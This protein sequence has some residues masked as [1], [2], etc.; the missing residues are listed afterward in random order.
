M[1][2]LPKVVTT[3][4][5]KW[6]GTKKTSP[7][8]APIEHMFHGNDDGVKF[9]N[10][11]SHFFDSFDESN[12]STTNVLFSN[13]IQYIMVCTISSLQSQDDLVKFTNR[14][15][16]YFY[17]YR[18]I[19][20]YLNYIDNEHK[21][22]KRRK[23]LLELRII[24]CRQLAYVFQNTMGEKPKVLIMDRSVLERINIRE[25]LMMITAILTDEDLIIFLVLSNLS[26]QSSL[27]CDDHRDHSWV[28][29][30]SN[31]QSIDLSLESVVSKFIDYKQTFATVPFDIPAFIALVEKTPAWTDP[32]YSTFS[33]Y[34][35]LL[36][37]LN[38]DVKTFFDEYLPHLPGWITKNKKNRSEHIGGL[39]QHVSQWEQLFANYLSSC[40]SNM[41]PDTFWK[42]FLYL[43]EKIDFN[44]TILAQ[45]SSILTKQ[46]N[47]STIEKVI[48]RINSA[49]VTQTRLKDESSSNLMKILETVF[50]AFISELFVTEH[51]PDIIRDYT[52]LNLYDIGL[53]LSPTRNLLQQSCLTI[54]NRLLFSFGHVG[55]ISEKIRLS[56][57][58]ICYFNDHLCRNNDPRVIIKDEWLKA[59]TLPI[60][61]MCSNFTRANYQD[62][63]NAHRNHPWNIYVWSRI[64]HLNIL[65][66]IIKDPA[67]IL[68]SIGDWMKR[69]G[70][71]IYKRD[72]A[73][74]IVFVN[75]VFEN[76][77]MK[78]M[79]SILISPNI[80]TIIRFVLDAEYDR[81]PLINQNQV[82]EFIQKGQ[83]W[84]RNI[85]LLKGE[86]THPF[87]NLIS[88]KIKDITRQLFFKKNKKKGFEITAV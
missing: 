52:W 43:I 46:S 68:L 37:N 76:I 11:T 19:A 72:D 7:S 63:C 13:D 9:F 8:V 10:L 80:E 39:L 60:M 73:L 65:K 32:T 81:S 66:S 45:M 24:L 71:N 48:E 28:S 12:R 41:H 83:Q 29:I 5:E 31:V 84:I 15:D 23:E 17:I 67:D 50:D 88:D 59:H 86:P 4:F 18:R 53:N 21:R 61:S 47:S 56:F 64:V 55:L 33:S 22:E 27:I 70:H 58:K 25:H 38:L 26:L 49:M 3:V 16:S 20:E 34:I 35:S 77:I 75:S 62:L 36:E 2:Y 14:S 74:T 79:N 30:L 85:F 78:H 1:H 42:V 51:D 57:E 44:E 6:T 40:A 54:I 82:N 87:L 69:V